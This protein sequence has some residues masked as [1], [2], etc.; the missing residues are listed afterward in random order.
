MRTRLSF[1]SN[2]SSC[3]FIIT[4]KSD[5]TLTL[6]DFCKDT[7]DSVLEDYN[8]NYLT[9]H[10]REEVLVSVREYIDKVQRGEGFPGT[11]KNMVLAAGEGGYYIFSNYGDGGTLFEHMYERS[12][13]WDV[14]KLWAVECGG[15][16]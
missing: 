4:N 10:T 1:V 9:S 8:K 6:E 11:S 13:N 2:S 5:H 3:S 15:Y 14:T 16:M 12:Y 7:V